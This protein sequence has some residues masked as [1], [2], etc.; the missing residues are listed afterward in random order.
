MKIDYIQLLKD[1]WKFTIKYKI[2]WVFGFILALFSGGGGSSGGFSSDSDS[3]G[4]STDQSL[5]GINSSFENITSSPAFWIIVLIAVV[6]IIVLIVLSW[7]LTSV[8]KVSLMRAYMLDL[9][10]LGDEIK[11]GKL[12]KGSHT[13]LLK[14]LVFDL[15]WFL[16][17]LPVLVLFILFIVAFII[18]PLGAVLTCCIGVPMI[19]V[20]AIIASAVKITGLR[21]IVLEEK[22]AMESIKESWTIFKTNFSKY[23]LAWLT[24]LLPGCLFGLITVFLVFLV[25][26]PLIVIVGLALSNPDITVLGMIL[27]V[28]GICGLGI[29]LAVI[30]SPLKV[31]IETYWTKFI[32]ELRKAENES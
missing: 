30:E 18:P 22:S 15:L 27:A 20:F 19:I 9:K 11:F 6:L 28:C 7:Y 25:I 13:Y 3:I 23:V 8:S 31:L 17:S 10:G 2:L 14:L 1:S 12:W 4:A 21:L 26:F 5:D 24:Q 16:I 32:L 29:L